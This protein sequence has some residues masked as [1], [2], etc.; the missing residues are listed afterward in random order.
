LFAAAINF[1]AD[2][3]QGILTAESV[4]VVVAKR[5]KEADAMDDQ[6]QKTYKVGEIYLT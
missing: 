2:Y 5:T 4:N 1:Y 3:Q 6:F